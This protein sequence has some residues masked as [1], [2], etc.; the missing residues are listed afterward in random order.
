[1]KEDK[2]LMGS[3]DDWL[4]PYLIMGKEQLKDSIKNFVLKDRE[5]QKEKVLKKLPSELK[6]SSPED[7]VDYKGASYDTGLA[8]GQNSTLGQI[9]KIIEQL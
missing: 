3:I 6:V 1:M 7:E 4:S 5:E 8:D 9:K 2:E